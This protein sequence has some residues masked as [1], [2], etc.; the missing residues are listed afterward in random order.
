MAKKSNSEDLKNKEHIVYSGIL[1]DGKIDNKLSFKGTNKE[2]V[3]FMNRNYQKNEIICY[4]TNKSVFCID[5]DPN[6]IENWKTLN[7]L[8]EEDIIQIKESKK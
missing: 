5:S 3:E 6:Q 4:F 2:I 8:I 1:E 7:Q